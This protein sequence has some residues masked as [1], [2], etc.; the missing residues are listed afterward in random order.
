M[1]TPRPPQLETPFSIFNQGVLTPNDAFFVRWHLAGI[2]TTVDGATHRIKV[3][4]SVKRPLS[5]S[6]DDLRTKYERVEIIAV[7]QCSGNSRWLVLAARA[8]R[9][10]G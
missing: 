9:A 4:G 2:P 10:V 7:N 6:V 3:H 5:L 1:L 8:R